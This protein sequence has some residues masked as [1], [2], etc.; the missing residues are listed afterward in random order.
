[1]RGVVEDGVGQVKL[2]FLF[3]FFYKPNIRA[4]KALC[5]FSDKVCGFNA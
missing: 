3:F 4:S 2:M 1:M 5:D